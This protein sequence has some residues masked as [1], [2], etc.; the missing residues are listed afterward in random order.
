MLVFVDCVKKDGEE[1][2]TD[3][4]MPQDNGDIAKEVGDGGY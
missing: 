3:H 4:K 2:V 1:A